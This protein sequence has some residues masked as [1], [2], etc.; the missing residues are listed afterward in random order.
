M[1]GSRDAGKLPSERPFR[2]IVNE[3]EIVTLMATPDELE[4]LAVGWLWAN[5][6]ISNVQEVKQLMADAPRALIWVEISGELP[7]TFKRTISSGCGGGALIA[8]LSAG[9]PRVESTL[10]VEIRTLARLMDDLFAQSVLYKKTGGVHGA[11]VA[12]P[13]KVLFIAEDIGRHNAVDKVIGRA[14]R[15]GEPLGGKLILTTGRISTEMMMKSAK[16]GFPIVASRT[17]ATDLAVDLAVES[18]ITVAG[19][20]RKGGAVVYSHPERLI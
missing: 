2:L 1:S 11:A 7:K 3:R 8:D 4:D 16:A 13:E 15:V 12:T 18:G 10:V 20:T 9:L 6:L 19:Y 14:L 17:A 5:D